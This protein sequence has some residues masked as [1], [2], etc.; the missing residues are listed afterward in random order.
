MS[1]YKEKG[2]EIVRNLLP[3]AFAH[4]LA[5]YFELIAYNKIRNIKSDEQVPKAHSVYGDPA[6]DHLGVFCLPLIEAV[7]Q[8]DLAPTYTYARIYQPG[9]ELKIHK[10]RPSCE[11]SVSL[12]LNQDLISE[13]PLMF[14]DF[15]SEIGGANLNPG[16]G[17]VYKGTDLKHWREPFKGNRQCQLFM[18]YVDKNGLHSE[19]V[20]DQRP[21]MGLP[22]SSKK[23]KNPS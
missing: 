18:H 12:C 3:T 6:F 16:D 11:H 13:W 7:V 21:S 4:Y 5:G 15:N 23:R 1:T 19:W 10:D 14:E 9:A 8:K 2:Y 20:L 17:V 22:E